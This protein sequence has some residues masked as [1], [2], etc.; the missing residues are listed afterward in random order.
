M[1]E[2]E[3]RHIKSRGISL[4]SH[5]ATHAKLTLLDHDELRRQLIGSRDTLTRLG[6]SF[7]SFSY[8]W[9]QWTQEIADTVK[10]CGYECAVAVGEQTRLRSADIYFLP[11]VAM[12]RAM[13][14]KRFQA[15]MG[16]SRIEMALRWRYRTLRGARSGV[17]ANS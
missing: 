7:L 15:L 17:S 9:G 3:V 8:P 16:R 12:G 5:T 4:G 11:R 2:D 14:L 1:T 13:D 6:E 10:A